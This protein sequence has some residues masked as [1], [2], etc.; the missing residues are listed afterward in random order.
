MTDQ[1]TQLAPVVFERIIDATPDE[2]F[3]LFTEPERL[4]RWKAISAAVD[5]RIGGD[6]RLT[7]TPGHIASGTFTEIEPGRR[8]VYTWGW[9]GSD[10]LPPGA[11][12]VLVDIEPAGDKTLVRVTHRGL[13]ADQAVSHGAGWTHYLERL[14]DVTASGDAGLDPWAAGPDELDHLAAV[15]ASWALCSHVME[16]FAPEHRELPTPCA[17]YKVHELVEH[18]LGSVRALGAMA[19]AEI[20]D[21]IDA[22]SA[23]DKVAQ[24]TESA[25]AAWRERG[26]GGDVPFGNGT[27]PATV[28]IGILGIEFFVHAWDF[29]QAIDQPFTAPAPL[30]AF[31]TA[32]AEE[33]IRPEARGEGKLFA[34]IATPGHDDA[35]SALMAFTGRAA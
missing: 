28:P 19:G 25:L 9:V 5:L 2:A 30:T 29:A 22:A 11:S 3:A 1:A 27:A 6:Y 26:A 24:A 13:S 12:T 20:P 21:E 17:D 34:A 14:G 4:R 10:D 23:E 31:V 8:V 16:Q 35:I 32:R 15:E 18:L 7:V 33:I